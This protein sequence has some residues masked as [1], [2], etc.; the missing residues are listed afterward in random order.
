MNITLK[1]GNI[2]V[3]L[4]A[5]NLISKKGSKLVAFLGGKEFQ[6]LG[7]WSVYQRLQIG[8]VHN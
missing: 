1:S 5:F 8:F 7:D 3:L 4:N 2:D 6:V